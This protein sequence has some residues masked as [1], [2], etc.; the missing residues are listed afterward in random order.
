MAASGGDAAGAVRVRYRRADGGF[1]ETTLD[2]LVPEDVA[3]GLPVREFRSYKG[4][5]HYSGW[6]WYQWPEWA[7]RLTPAEGL[8]PGPFRSTLAA[9]LLLPGHPARAIGEVITSLH[10]YRSIVINAAL[11]T[12]AEGGHG[13][14]LTAIRCLAGYLDDGGSPID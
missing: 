3:D 2:C 7:I 1:A 12:L 4:R 5:L 8:L 11:R 13:T 10:S 9:C 6:Y 14:V